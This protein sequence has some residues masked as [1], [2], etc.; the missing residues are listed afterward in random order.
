[1]FVRYRYLRYLKFL[2]RCSCGSRLLRH[3]YFRM[4]SDVFKH[5][6]F[7]AQLRGWGGL[8]RLFARLATPP[9]PPDRDHL[10]KPHSSSTE[11]AVYSLT[12]S[13]ASFFREATLPCS[14]LLLSLTLLLQRL[15]K[16]CLESR[17]HQ[18]AMIINHHSPGSRTL[19]SSLLVFSLDLLLSSLLCFLSC[20]IPPKSAEPNT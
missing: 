6:C 7:Q 1:L 14:F 10:I 4:F 18:T 19:Y 3:C 13:P 12:F 11:K 17:L 9:A 5:K 15:L 16:R 20:S 2:K 8:I